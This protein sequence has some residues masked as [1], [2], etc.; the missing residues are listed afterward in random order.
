MSTQAAST[1]TNV[2]LTVKAARSHRGRVQDVRV[3]SAR[4]TP[5]HWQRMPTRRRVGTRVCKKELESQ[6]QP[7][8]TF[9]QEKGHKHRLHALKGR[10]LQNVV[11][12]HKRSSL[13]LQNVPAH[14]GSF[15]NPCPTSPGGAEGGP[16]PP[17]RSPTAQPGLLT[18][19]GPPAP[20][21]LSPAAWLSL[22]LSNSLF[23]KNRRRD[24]CATADAAAASRAKPAEQ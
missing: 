15:P 4:P 24:S 22:P 17:F 20:R 14:I 12:L 8:L 6:R 9:P 13:S 7:H 3:V 18:A 1:L 10:R 19:E 2:N 23:N 16:R 5:R 21:T 11:L